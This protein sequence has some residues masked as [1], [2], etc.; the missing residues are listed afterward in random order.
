MFIPDKQTGE[1][2]DTMTYLIMDEFD[3]GRR[4]GHFEDKK[5]SV[6]YEYHD[7]EGCDWE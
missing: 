5:D 6:D 3:S 1:E 4:S 7:Y 2:D